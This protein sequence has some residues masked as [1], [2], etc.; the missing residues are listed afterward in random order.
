MRPFCIA[1]IGSVLGIIMGLYLNSIAFFILISAIL[2]TFTFFYFLF[3]IKN[4]TCIKIIGTFLLFCL[5]FFIYTNLMESNI[6]KINKKYDNKEVII[7]AI[8]TSDKISKD[9]KDIYTI[10]VIGVNNKKQNFK[11]ILNIKKEK[12]S[13]LD[14]KYGD[15][16]SIIST[17][18]SPSIA[19]NKGG[20]DYKQYLKTKKIVGI[21]SAKSSEIKVLENNKSNIFNKVVHDIKNNTICS[22]KQILPKDTAN[23][24]TALLLGEKTELSEDVQENFRKSNLSHML[25]I[26]GAHVSYILLGINT[27]IQKLKFHKRWCK[28]P[29]IIF[30]LFFMD[31]VNFTP[32]V[33]RACIMAILQ[34]LASIFF[35]KSDT[36]QNLAISSLIILIFNPYTILDIGF[37]LSFAGTIGI[38]IFSERLKKLTLKVEHTDINKEKKLSKRIIFQKLVQNIKEICIVTISANLL[39]IPVMMYHFNTISFTF[40]ISNLLASPILGLSIILSMIFLILLFIFKPLAILFSLLLQPILQLLILIAQIS[41]K[42]PFSKVLVPTPSIFQIIIYYLILIVIFLIKSKNLSINILKDS[43]N[44]QGY[45][46]NLK[47]QKYFKFILL[48]LIFLIISPYIINVFP[49]N[50]LTINFIDVGQGDSM[51]IETPF[52]KTILIDGGGSET[53]SFDVGEKTLI[54]Y[55]L[56]K[57]I[58]K[59]DYIMFSHFDTDHCQRFIKSYGKNKSKKYNY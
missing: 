33:T 6:N 48:A 41:S 54:P 35:K 58:M 55:L 40:I 24:C 25:A 27:L 31:L 9:Y 18:E 34:L 28:I 42:L 39:I 23:L 44:N 32:S 21:V 46:K 50:K 10:K 17:Y 2:I 29:L 51:L 19:R 56:D 45:Y 15:K 30:L 38:V 22:I 8:V 37:Q 57:G 5:F 12:N 3:N 7:T 13:Q 43:S 14:L 11:I 59:I 20:F 26:S 53:G 36:Y 4:K 52:H 16:I 47:F 1:T 49:C